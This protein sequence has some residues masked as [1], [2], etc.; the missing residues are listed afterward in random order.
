M[1]AT[2][3]EQRRAELAALLERASYLTERANHYEQESIKLQEKRARRV[4]VIQRGA[5]VTAATRITVSMTNDDIAYT[6]NSTDPKLAEYS[7]GMVIVERRAAMYAAM[8]A[9]VRM[10]ALIHAQI[11]PESHRHTAV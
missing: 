3:T 2:L 11:F 4:A 5:D 6:W 8:A 10:Q 9:D 1:T 7:A